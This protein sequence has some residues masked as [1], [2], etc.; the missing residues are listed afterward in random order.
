[1][2]DKFNDREKSF[3]KKF[4]IDQE[5]QFKIAARTNKYLSE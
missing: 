1:M 4:Q 2:S 3:E 5:M